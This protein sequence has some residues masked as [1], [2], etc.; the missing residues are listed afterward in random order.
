MQ[1]QSTRS[2]SSV[3]SD[4]GQPLLIP[5]IGQDCPT[6]ER[7]HGIFATKR[8]VPTS[9]FAASKAIR[10][11]TAGASAMANALHARVGTSFNPTD[12]G[13]ELFTSSLAVIF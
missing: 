10:K 9:G 6:N 8:A 1:P 12:R 3:P 5:I 7:M 2:G 13:R 11:G 4:L